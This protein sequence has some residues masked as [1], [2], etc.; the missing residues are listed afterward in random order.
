M[1]TEKKNAKSFVQAQAEFICKHAAW[2]LIAFLAATALLVPVAS[3]LKL[4]ANFLDLLPANHPSIVN[5]KDLMKHVGGTSFLIT[6]VESPD[7]ETANQA[8]KELGRQAALFPEIEYVDNRTD[9]PAFLD[10][11]LLF[12]KLE[13]VQKLRKDV[14]DLMG[15]YRRKN[16]PFYLDIVEEK[17]PVIDPQTF[18]LEEKVSRI[19]GFSAKEK[20]SFMKVMLLKPKHPV[21]D[22]VETEKLFA[23]IQQ[24]F[25]EIKAGLSKPVTLGL[26][27]PY[28]TR[29]QEYKTINR[30][31]KRTGIIALVLLFLVNVVAFRNIRSLIYA[32]LPLAI[33]TIW[34]WAFAQVS[35]GYL[36]LITAF[37]AAIL[38]GMGGDY[39]YHI[40]V[41]FEEDLQQT[42]DPVKAMQMTFVELWDPLWASMWTTAVVFFAM[43]VS[44]FEGFRHFGIIA[45]FGIII[46]FVLVLFVQPSLIV[47]IEKYFPVKRPAV[48]DKVIIS[49][50]LIYSIIAAGL[51]LSLFS[52]TQISKTKF[53][54]NFNDLQAK[55]D[56]SIV[57]A[58]KISNHFGVRLTPLIFM[59]PNR[60]SAHELTQRINRY[61]ETNPETLFDFAASVTSHVPR[62]QA[63]KIAVLGE[64]RTV[65]EKYRPVISKLDAEARK[66]IESLEKQLSPKTFGFDDL[67]SGVV[68]QYEG[69]DHKIST[70]FV[71]PNQRIFNG[72]VAMRFVKEARDFPVPE[73]VRV[74]GEP[75]IY[76]DIL[77]L[78][79]KD[80]PVVLGISTVVVFL[81]VLFHFKRLDH[82]LWV[83]APLAIGGLWMIGM[84]GVNGLQF[85]F[86]NMLIIPSILGVGIDNGIYIFSR[87]KER[88][89][90]NFFQSMGKS[91]KGVLLSSST[92]I[93]GFASIM[94]VSHQ[95]MASMGKL[96]FF[97][98]FGCLLSSVL[99]VPALI[100]FF[101]LKYAHLFRRAGEEDGAV[102][103]KE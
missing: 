31:L 12:L 2:I 64:V 4:H 46:S 21:S 22:F 62:A 3:R 83:H 93:A 85:N 48:E 43:M 10:S 45:G 91:L 74:A 49:K 96:A 51:L 66:K 40:L 87:Y 97:G 24:S 60:E 65:L 79:E 25:Q 33:A 99:F 76:A 50:P 53:D 72:K 20:D 47:L 57:Q 80:T 98:F 17:E 26:T 13:S 52:A 38:F 34:I 71:Y 15:Y 75:A 73:G 59:T 67:P 69:N 90:E 27:G 37:L 16:N 89:S 29:Y 102:E 58:E 103:I 94:C 44:Q 19:G 92:N 28:R 70:V 14:T 32:Y 86:F 84:M 68:G 54:Y 35:I 42:G 39:T 30:D 95:G 77:S 55:D 36:N 81:L 82:A 5:L 18:E 101:E 11:K 9:S 100:E 56:D 23:E 78:I 8:A 61:I 88:R 6:I 7:E 1:T 41:S 63:E